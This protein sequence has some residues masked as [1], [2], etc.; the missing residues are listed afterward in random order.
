MLVNG[1]TEL[2][3]VLRNEIMLVQFVLVYGHLELLHV[4]VNGHIELL[5]V[6][7]AWTYRVTV[8]VG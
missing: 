4:L 3:G 5:H 6:V 1:H 2:L 8:C 7:G